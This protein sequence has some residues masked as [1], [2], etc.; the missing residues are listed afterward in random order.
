MHLA[1]CTSPQQPSDA[2]EP[3]ITEVERSA[4]EQIAGV[5]LHLCSPPPNHSTPPCPPA[6]SRTAAPPR[7]ASHDWDRTC[8]IDAE[9]RRRSAHRWPAAGPRCG[10]R[11]PRALPVRSLSEPC[12]NACWGGPCWRTGATWRVSSC[13]APRAVPGFEDR[14]PTDVGRV[15]GNDCCSPSSKNVR[16]TKK[17]L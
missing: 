6:T 3:H 12:V 8:S 16:V 5:P 17:V 7:G 15:H 11:S 14:R 13:P 2:C 9:T 10:G 1:E 4:G